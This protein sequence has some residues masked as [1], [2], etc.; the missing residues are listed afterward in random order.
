MIALLVGRAARLTIVACLAVAVG[1]SKATETADSSPAPNTEPTPRTEP[2]SRTEPP[3]LLTRRTFPNLVVTQSNAAGRP[4][5]RMGIEVKVDSLGRADV[6][7]LKVT[8]VVDSQNR[9]AVEQW[10]ESV[11]F[12]P[13]MRDGQAVSGIFKMSLTVRV[14]YRRL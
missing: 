1:C 6:R 7:T 3:R 8:G 11:A 10:L 4:S 14:E 5:L 9:Q 12:R 13:A 2:A